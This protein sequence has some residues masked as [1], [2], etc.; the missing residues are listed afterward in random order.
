MSNSRPPLVLEHVRDGP[1]SMEMRS[2]TERSRGA[3]RRT[4][5]PSWRAS[6]AFSLPEPE[7]AG[8]A[9]VPLARGDGGRRGVAAVRRARRRRP[10]AALRSSTRRER[11]RRSRRPP[12]RHGGDQILRLQAAAAWR[13]RGRTRP[14]RAAPACDAPPRR[15]RRRRRGRLGAV[16]VEERRRRRNVCWGCARGTRRRAS[17]ERG[18]ATVR[19]AEPPRVAPVPRR[20]SGRSATSSSSPGR[21]RATRATL[22]R[23]SDVLMPAS[24]RDG[25]PP[26]AARTV[27]CTAPKTPTC[28]DLPRVPQR[29][30]LASEVNALG[31]APGHRRRPRPPPGPARFGAAFR[32]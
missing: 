1:S 23:G 15:E 14:A 6:M 32:S 17:C 7:V 24:T 18:L 26:S 12:R 10:R 20:Q 8:S 21:A 2:M 13:G 4:P 27:L 11:Q 30:P 22:A 25:V 28:S 19:A 5:R 31:L 16:N 29:P 3:E 9:A